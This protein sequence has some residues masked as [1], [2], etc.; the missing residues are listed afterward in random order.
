MKSR[1]AIDWLNFFIADVK[2]G[3]G[4]F[5]AIYLEPALGRDPDRTRYDDCRYSDRGWARALRGAR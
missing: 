1:T 3:L 5:L 2:D 4:P